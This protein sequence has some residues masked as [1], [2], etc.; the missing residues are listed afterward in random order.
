MVTG[1]I[2][3]GRRLALLTV[4]VNGAGEMSEHVPRWRAI[5]R[6]QQACWREIA[7]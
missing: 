6:S 1:G 4:A 5:W 7:G 3:E 2:R